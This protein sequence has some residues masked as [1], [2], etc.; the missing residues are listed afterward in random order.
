MYY[1]FI[2]QAIKFIFCFIYQCLTGHILTIIELISVLSSLFCKI[3]ILMY[4]ISDW[5][6]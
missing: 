2:A 4:N 5:I 3:N 6:F 1:Y